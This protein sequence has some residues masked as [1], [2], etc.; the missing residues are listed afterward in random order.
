[1]PLVRMRGA[2]PIRTAF[3]GYMCRTVLGEGECQSRYVNPPNFF[4]LC[5]YDRTYSNIVHHYSSYLAMNIENI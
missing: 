4:F 2:V 5:L 1:M 3:S